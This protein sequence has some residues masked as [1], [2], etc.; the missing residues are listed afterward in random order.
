MRNWL[1]K[2]LGIVALEARLA[3]MP[4]AQL[5]EAQVVAQWMLEREQ[6]PP[7]SPKHIA[8]TN[9]LRSMGAEVGD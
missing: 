1:R 6:H 4:A 2:W 8:L 3:E 9:R 5:A 7:G